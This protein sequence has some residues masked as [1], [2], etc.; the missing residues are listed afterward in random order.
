ME[1]LTPRNSDT[2]EKICKLESDILQTSTGFVAMVDE[3]SIY[4]HKCVSLPPLEIPRAVFNEIV[5]FWQSNKT[6]ES[7]TYKNVK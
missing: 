7:E 6:P 3:D 5:D 4:I 2:F 1:I